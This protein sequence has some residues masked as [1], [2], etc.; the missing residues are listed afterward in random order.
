MSE[1]QKLRYAIMSGVMDGSKPIYIPKDEFTDLKRTQE[2]LRSVLDIEATFDLLLENYAE[3]EE[4]FLCLSLRLSL[5]GEQGERPEVYREMNRRLMNLLSSARLYLDQIPRELGSFYGKESKQ[6][7]T[8]NQSISRQYDS[9]LAYR[10][11]EALRNHAQ[12]FLG[13]Q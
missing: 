12:H 6:T 3:F 5:F 1:G 4:D 7:E 13:F 8:V 9:S 10:A 2:R 11:L